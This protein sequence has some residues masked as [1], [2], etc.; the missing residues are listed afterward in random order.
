[1]S[2]PDVV[3]VPP[4][5]HDFQVV[6]SKAR[7]LPPHCTYDCASNLQP[8]ITPLKGRLYSLSSPE[9]GAMET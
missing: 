4:V 6:F 8:G 1:M 5:N 3:G 9:S 2:T 7:A